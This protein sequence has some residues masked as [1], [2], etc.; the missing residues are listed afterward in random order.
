MTKFYIHLG[1]HK[2]GTKFFQHKVFPNLDKTKFIYNPP[3][4]TQLACDLMKAF[5]EDADLV[6]REVIKEKKQLTQDYPNHKIIISREILS[7]DLF[8]FYKNSQE[9]IGRLHKAF[10][11][12]YIIYSKRFQVDWIV[13]CYRE[14][15]HEHHYQRIEDFLSLKK[16]NKEFVNNKFQDLDIHKYEAHLKELF[17]PEQLHLL[18]YEDFKENKLNEVDKIAKIIGSSEISVKNDNDG[19]PNRGYSAFSIKLS[20]FRFK[21]YKF[22]GL[23]RLLVHRPIFFFGNKGIP[24]GFENLSVL[25]KEKYWHDGFLRDNEEVRSDS[26]PN[27]TFKEKI[28]LKLSWRNIIKNGVDKVFYWDWDLLKNQRTE[29]E[30]YFREKNKIYMDK[31]APKIYFEPKNKI[32]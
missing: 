12:A 1:L 32:S 18:Y 16:I 29:M 27:L 5:P 4:L 17:N 15:I 31:N 3:R 8:S 30:R 25:S 2:T 26:Y 22:F 28:K 21:F 6:I 14:S 23:S 11:D 10:N 20:I 7:G 13:S 9:T 19:R 24:A